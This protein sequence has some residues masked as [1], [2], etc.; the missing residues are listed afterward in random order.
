MAF[1]N[2]KTRSDEPY[3]MPLDCPKSRKIW[4]CAKTK[5]CLKKVLSKQDC[6]QHGC[7]RTKLCP[8]KIVPKFFQ[9]IRRIL[10]NITRKNC[11]SKYMQT[12]I[13]DYT[14]WSIQ[15]CRV[16]FQR[17]RENLVH[18]LCGKVYLKDWSKYFCKHAESL[19]LIYKSNLVQP[20]PPQ[21]EF[22]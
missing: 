19:S 15:L 7:T 13:V 8:R 10:V 16:Y 4:L 1:E 6:T 18:I 11:V 9:S 3:L 2:F 17:F 22:H 14:Y 20:P 21:V 5:L 12:N